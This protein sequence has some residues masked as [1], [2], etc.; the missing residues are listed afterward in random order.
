MMMPIVLSR[1]RKPYLGLMLLRS[2][3]ALAAVHASHFDHITALPVKP[4][5]RSMLDLEGT[6]CAAVEAVN[7]KVGI[8]DDPPSSFL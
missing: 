1:L 4:I 2:I 3:G 5:G 7:I 6:I 8:P